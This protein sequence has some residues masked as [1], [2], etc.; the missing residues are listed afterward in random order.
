MDQR[1]GPAAASVWRAYLL[2]LSLGVEELRDSSD[3]LGVHEERFAVAAG[4]Q[5]ELSAGGCRR[6]PAR[7]AASLT[8]RSAPPTS[9]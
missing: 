5:P 6:L 1:R 4:R 8:A 7:R 3:Q 9:P 2:K